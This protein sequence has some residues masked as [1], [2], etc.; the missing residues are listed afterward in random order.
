MSA[1][2]VL[3]VT[4]NINPNP[5]I[6]LTNTPPTTD[7]TCGQSNGAINLPAGSI[8]P[9]NGTA[10]Y[11]YQWYNGSNVLVGDTLPNLIGVG[12]SSSY[13]LH[14]TDAHGCVASATGGALTF[15]VN[16]S[17][18]VAANIVATPQVGTA[19]LNV[20]FTNG[21]T[22]GTNYV[23][24]YGDMANTTHILS[25][26]SRTTFT[27]TAAGSYIATLVASNG[28]CPPSTAT[29]TILVEVPTTIIIPNIFSPNGDGT[30]DQFFINNTGMKSLNCDIFNRWG[31]LLYSITAPDQSWDGKTPNGLA[32]PEGTYMYI[33]EA[34]GLDGKTY[35]QQGTVTLVR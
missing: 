20:I 25:D 30:N 1:G 7:A 6:D 3:T 17:G 23:W 8:P 19:P 22:G 9:S 24:S 13:S 27:Y 15:S 31:Q 10:P 18:A 5:T 26:T 33:L 16:A 2:N 35:K 28:T 11:H 4:V 32:A 21:S 34:L 14:I 29:V 12:P